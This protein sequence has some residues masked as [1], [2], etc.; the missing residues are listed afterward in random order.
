VE[1]K[2][3]GEKGKR[4]GGKSRNVERKRKKEKINYGKS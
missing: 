2:G 4:E 3:G 1:V